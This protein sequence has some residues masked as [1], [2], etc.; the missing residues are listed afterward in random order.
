MARTRRSSNAS[1]GSAVPDREQVRYQIP[2][3]SIFNTYGGN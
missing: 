2:T 1:L 3:V